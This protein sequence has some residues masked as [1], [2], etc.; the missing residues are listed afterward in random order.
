MY[1]V[2]LRLKVYIYEYDEDMDLK[3]A[4]EHIIPFAVIKCRWG[5][6]LDKH[7]LFASVND[8]AILLR[9][10]PPPPEP[11]G[12]QPRRS[13]L[14]TP[15]G[16]EKLLAEKSY[17]PPPPD[18]HE[19]FLPGPLRKPPRM[20]MARAK[21]TAAPAF[22]GPPVAAA[23]TTMVH[24]P[25]VRPV[26]HA[27]P[28]PTPNRQ[29]TPSGSLGDSRG[30]KAPLQACYY[31]L[32]PIVASGRALQATADASC[33]QARAPS[34]DGLPRY[35]INTC[36]LV[37]PVSKPLEGADAENKKPTEVESWQFPVE[38]ISYRNPS[39][40]V[41]EGLLQP[42]FIVSGLISFSRL[43]H[44]LAGV[45]E[46]SGSASPPPASVSD[47][48][49]PT[50][51]AAAAAAT[52]DAGVLD[53][54]RP[55]TRPTLPPCPPFVSIDRLREWIV[56]SEE[57]VENNASAKPSRFAGYRGNYFLL[58]L[59]DPTTQR[60]DVAKL[61]ETLR[62]RQLACF[63][64]MPCSQ[65]AV[66]CI[67]PESDFSRSLG[68]PQLESVDAVSFHGI[69]LLPHSIHSSLLVKCTC[70]FVQRS[71]ISDP[72]NPKTPA[73]SDNQWNISLPT[74]V[75][76]LPDNGKS[77]IRK[78]IDSMWNA[79][80]SRKEQPSSPAVTPTF[81]STSPP[82]ASAPKHSTSVAP[83]TDTKSKGSSSHDA[84][85]SPSVSC[86][87]DLDTSC[88]SGVASPLTP[89][90]KLNRKR[91][92]M[93]D[94]MYFDMPKPLVP[95]AP[96]EYSPDAFPFNPP[97][98]LD[99]AFDRV[100][101]VD[102]SGP[103]VKS[104]ADTSSVAKRVHSPQAMFGGYESW[105]KGRDRR[106]RDSL[107]SRRSTFQSDGMIR[108]DIDL[109]SE[110]STEPRR[111]LLPDPKDE[112]RVILISPESPDEEQAAPP[113]PPPTTPPEEEEGEIVDDDDDDEDDVEATTV[114]SEYSP[115]S[116]TS[117][118]QRLPQESPHKP[119]YYPSPSPG[120]RPNWDFNQQSQNQP[121]KRRKQLEDVDY[122]VAQSGDGSGL[123]IAR[124][125][126]YRPSASTPVPHTNRFKDTDYRY[127]VYIPK[128]AEAVSVPVKVINHAY[129]AENQAWQQYNL[130]I[131][132]PESDSQMSP[133]S[134]SPQSRPSHSRSH[135]RV[136]DSS[137]GCLL[138]APQIIP[139]TP[140]PIAVSRPAVVPG[141]YLPSG[142]TASPGRRG[143]GRPLVGVPG[144]IG[145]HPLS[146]AGRT[147]AVIPTYYTPIMTRRR[148]PQPP[149]SLRPAHSVGAD[150]SASSD[151]TSGDSSGV[152]SNM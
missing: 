25:T 57:N 85:A 56:P 23:P 5:L 3:E 113:R 114:S 80:E 140:I 116:S 131:S 118:P 103:T 129:D 15:P 105:K 9:V 139:L 22:P 142:T 128:S 141:F 87:M 46:P 98:S 37:W 135:P 89:I 108:Q 147:A 40:Q 60:C 55:R 59:P 66:F 132:S 93:A 104:S 101:V 7:P 94:L 58:T 18:W 148:H 150:A 77:L 88:E 4:P 50:L 45:E 81:S 43:H 119:T 31:A 133:P 149:Q 126:D 49:S 78:T 32:D 138:P 109:D 117:T 143:F 28:L 27:A 127:Q 26:S 84:A 38:I 97:A 17:L 33:A 92:E 44:E 99:N 21:L 121:K 63:I 29:R 13:L 14:S 47:S 72:P 30:V 86:D 79:K 76:A 11:E 112:K 35:L 16:K 70:Q 123:K 134:T 130:V 83:I 67:F 144:I 24:P 64:K 8:G 145:Y 107:T 71:G 68:I 100:E 36:Y 96:E 102:I 151:S 152:A 111:S 54:R 110:V 12:A 41:Y 51:P 137:S 62:S 19:G 120:K 74:L 146:T 48:A 136:G 34:T 42:R 125:R 61:C 10:S 69:L 82:K 115:S 6:S 53:P 39:F 124:D 52:L 20:S 95:P 1:A 91:S 90:R 106:G 75:A 122:R 65:N 73:P 2:V